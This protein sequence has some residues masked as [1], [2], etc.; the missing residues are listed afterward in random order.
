[1]TI[2]RR[3]AAVA[4]TFGC[5]IFLFSALVLADEKKTEPAKPIDLTWGVKIPMRDGTGL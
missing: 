5:V 1:M 4:S 2:L 3:S